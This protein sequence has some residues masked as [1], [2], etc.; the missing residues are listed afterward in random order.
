[1]KNIYKAI[2][3]LQQEV[4][5]IHKGTEGFGY[6]YADLPAIFEVINPLMKKHGLGF[7]Q[8]VDGM[9]LVT[10]VFHVESGEFIAS[11][12]DI[13]QDVQLAKMN[14][15]QVLGSAITYI[16]RYALSAMLGLV[17]DED[18]DASGTQVAAKTQKDTAT[19]RTYSSQPDTKETL[20]QKY[21]NAVSEKQK[22]WARARLLE[23]GHDFGDEEVND[24][25]A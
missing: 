4:P 17:T 24:I 8:M 16:R 14:A 3:E 11:R 23:M 12:T 2:A 25:V 22:G 10:H 21:H 15:F 7:T 13:P 1:M 9:S 6:S 19:T 18:T 5:V 20:L